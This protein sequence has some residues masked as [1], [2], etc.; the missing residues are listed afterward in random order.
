MTLISCAADFYQ[1]LVDGKYK[2]AEKCIKKMKGIDKYN[3]AETLIKEYIE[4]EEYDRAVY[5]Y[6]KCTP[7]HCDN[8]GLKYPGLYCHGA[9]YEQ[10]VTALF[11]R[12]LWILE[13]MTKCGST[14]RGSMRGIRDMTQ[15]LIISL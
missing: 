6:E 7:E 1:L 14:L 3:C 13:T 15:K 9:N 12:Y 2:E 5:V 10:T 11:A 4:I 8:S